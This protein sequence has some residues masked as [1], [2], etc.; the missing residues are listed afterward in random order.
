[1]TMN[2]AWLVHYPDALPLTGGCVAAV[3]NFDGVHAGHRHLLAVAKAEAVVRG[4]PLVVLTFE[5]HPRSV[6]RP[7][8]P[9]KRL[10]TLEQKT[11]LLGEAG[12]DGVAVLPFTPEVGGWTPEAFIEDILVEWLRAGVVCVGENFRYGHKAQGDV[13]LLAGHKKFT[14]R[15]VPL[16]TDE[17][18]VVSS[19]RLR[20]S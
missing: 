20:G 14:T 10:S 4:L 2:D 16:L 8:L 18:G 11:A 3:G 12:V 19:S 13:A 1:M 7:E 17:A 15:A 5:P 9:L 6:L